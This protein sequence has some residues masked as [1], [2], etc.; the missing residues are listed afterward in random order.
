MEGDERA[1]RGD[2][3]RE[4]MEGKERDIRRKGRTTCWEEEMEE[5]GRIYYESTKD[6]M[7]FWW[8]LPKSYK[9]I[10]HQYMLQDFVFYML[11]IQAKN[12]LY[13]VM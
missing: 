9:N 8:I 2:N 5:Q 7:R 3:E 13:R 12:S 6:E 11:N 1:I 4:R 10:I